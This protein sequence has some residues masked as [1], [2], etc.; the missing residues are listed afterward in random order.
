MREVRGCEVYGELQRARDFV[1]NAVSL[2][3]H[4]FLSEEEQAHV[5]SC[6]NLWD[7]V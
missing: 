6:C 7:A 5:V 3:V 4:P 1:D 2:P